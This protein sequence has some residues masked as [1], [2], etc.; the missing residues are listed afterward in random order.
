[1]RP[2]HRYNMKK[3]NEKQKN[4][5]KNTTPINIDNIQH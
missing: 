5:K 1:M 3:K 2:K 4:R